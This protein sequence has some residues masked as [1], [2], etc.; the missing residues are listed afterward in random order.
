MTV[1]MYILESYHHQRF[2]IA[3][4]FVELKFVR[5]NLGWG[6]GIDCRELG[7]LSRWNNF[8]VYFS[9]FLRQVAMECH[10]FHPSDFSGTYSHLETSKCSPFISS[11]MLQIFS[12]FSYLHQFVQPTRYGKWLKNC[13]NFELASSTRRKVSL[14]YLMALVE[15]GKK[16]D[17]YSLLLS[18]VTKECLFKM[19]F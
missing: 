12:I 2:C 18:S 17:I 13:S 16:I 10:S 1:E 14:L 15:I 9:W 8:G 19:C 7:V 6:N 5:V 3:H 4:R 11:H